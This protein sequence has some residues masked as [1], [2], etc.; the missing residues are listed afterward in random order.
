MIGST[1]LDA[2]TMVLPFVQFLAA[3]DPKY[4]RTIEALNCLPENGGIVSNP[5]VFRYEID[6]VDDGTGSKEQG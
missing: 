6:K 5:L 1:T 3:S 4:C 2:S